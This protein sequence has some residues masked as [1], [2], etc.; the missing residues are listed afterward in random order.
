MAQIITPYTIFFA[1]A[2]AVSLGAITTKLHL[3][4]RKLRSRLEGT[5]ISKQRRLSLGGVP[6][7][8]TLS[9]QF[10][11]DNH[12][13]IVDLK[14]KFDTVELTRRLAYCHMASALLEDVPLGEQPP[15]GHRRR[16]ASVRCASPDHLA[17]F[18]TRSMQAS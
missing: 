15:L 2:C 12:S 8:P 7:A 3:L 6:I 17:I 16:R 5:R 4:I 1:L 9:R 14:S 11:V 18:P 13:T 10:S